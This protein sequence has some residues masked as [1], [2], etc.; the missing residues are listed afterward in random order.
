[1][2][3]HK[4]SLGQELLEIIPYLVS[5]F[6]SG[7]LL[8]QLHAVQR[9]QPLIYLS[10]W[11]ALFLV[12]AFFLVRVQE[13]VLNFFVD[14]SERPPKKRSRGVRILRWILLFLILP[15]ALMA[16]Y[17]FARPS[18]T[19][20]FED[21]LQLNPETSASTKIA[22][23]VLATSDLHTKESGVTALGKIGTG[24]STDE[25]LR[26]LEEEK[27]CFKDEYCNQAMI[28]SLLK[29]QNHSVAASM[30]P[31][32]LRHLDQTK[33][34]A[35]NLSSG[36]RQSD[37]D[38]EFKA[39]HKALQSGTGE[40]KDKQAAVDK[41]DALQRQVDS[42]LNDLNLTSPTESDDTILVELILNTYA[43]LD[44]SHMDN[45]VKDVSKRV[46]EDQDFPP[47]VRVD[48]IAVIGHLG[49]KSDA[50]WL[51]GFMDQK[52]EPLRAAAIRAIGGIYESSHSKSKGD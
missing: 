51:L 22:N 44:P 20:F 2:T 48:A 4:S 28:S 12:G 49:K 46:S 15:V 33:S 26:L 29:V 27:G 39:F 3:A 1:M 25:L 19:S 30:F 35:K 9:F 17:D 13:R 23:V 11:Y 41:L 16:L 36:Q 47:Q 38:S 45:Q 5:A 14:T 18:L 7:L 8:S 21:L 31:L 24:R 43:Q 6:L 34:Q 32:L 10:I 42:G 50:A 40:D 37:I 52:N